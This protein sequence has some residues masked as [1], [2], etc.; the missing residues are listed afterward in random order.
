MLKANVMTVMRARLCMA[1]LSCYW[2][3]LSMVSVC[4][5]VVLL[6]RGRCDRPTRRRSVDRRG[7]A[8]N[9]LDFREVR[10][11]QL[12]HHR[13]GIAQFDGHR[14]VGHGQTLGRQRRRRA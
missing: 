3:G 8:R 7:D 5:A 4:G 9:Q 13:V 11:F 10:Q 12:R 14:Q 6:A 2:S 1:V